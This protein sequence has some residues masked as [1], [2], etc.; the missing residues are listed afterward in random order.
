MEIQTKREP[1]KVFKLK[2]Q[3][4]VFLQ[5]DWFILAFAFFTAICW[6]LK[7]EYVFYLLVGVLSTYLF[8]SQNSL[9]PM[10]VVFAYMFMAYSGKD[11][12]SYMYFVFYLACG[13]F[14]ATGIIYRFYM[15]Y[16]TK[17]KFKQGK[18]LI[19]MLIAFLAV[20]LGGLG[21][22]GY[23]YTFHIELI[24]VSLL[25]V[26]IYVIAT[27]FIQEDIR[28]YLC[29]IFLGASIIL[30]IEMVS[31]FLET[32]NVSTEVVQNGVNLGWITGPGIAMI[33]T[34]SVIMMLYKASKHARYVFY[35]ALMA[36]LCCFGVF[37]S[38]ATNIFFIAGVAMFFAWVFGYIKA[39]KKNQYLGLS[40]GFMVGAI[41]V[42]AFILIFRP[43][44][45]S[46]YKK[47]FL[48]QEGYFDEY[49]MAIKMI[50]EQPLFGCGFF[51]EQVDQNVLLKICDTP[52]QIMFSTGIIGL[53]L[54]CY[55]YYSRFKIQTEYFSKYKMFAMIAIVVFE[56]YGLIEN[57]FLVIPLNILILLVVVSCEKETSIAEKLHNK[58]EKLNV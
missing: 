35:Y 8:F 11:A 13:I 29:K 46:L 50:F 25:F 7:I 14:L 42:F 57:M 33:F 5:S 4:D 31:W 40:I 9:K 17:T 36:T 19:P 52:L 30:V 43:G 45:L 3:F 58:G 56:F 1:Q 34:I 10:L 51:A 41:S 22:S 27:N 21:Y 48:S 15:L 53:I 49:R 24:S 55:Y 47:L 44:I 28:S 18:F 23:N 26:F 2:K 16:V 20:I 12:W 6:V 38:Y 54:F 37:L 32:T 39:V